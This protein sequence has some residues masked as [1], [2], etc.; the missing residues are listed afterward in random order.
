MS[1]LKYPNFKR[2]CESAN[3][4]INPV[5]ESE[6]AERKTTWYIWGKNKNIII[7]KISNQ[8]ADS[9]YKA[10]IGRDECI[11]VEKGMME[12]YIKSYF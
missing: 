8:F 3:A 1:Q 6:C 2:F 11:Y 9:V 7:K 12:K 10:E 4:L 5:F